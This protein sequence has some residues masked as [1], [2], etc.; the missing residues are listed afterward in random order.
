MLTPDL[1]MTYTH[2]SLQAE[3]ITFINS[4]T[5]VSGPTPRKELVASHHFKF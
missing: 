1:T 2:I 3:T 5:L 4:H